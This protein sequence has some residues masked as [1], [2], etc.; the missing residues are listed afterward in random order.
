MKFNYT[1][2]NNCLYRHEQSPAKAEIPNNNTANFTEKL[3]RRL[4]KSFSIRDLLV[5]QSR[6]FKT[7]CHFELKLFKTYYRKLFFGSFRRLLNQQI[8]Y[9]KPANIYDKKYE[10]TWIKHRHNNWY[11][12]NYRLKRLLQYLTQYF[13]IFF[14]FFTLNKCANFSSYYKFLEVFVGETIFIVHVTGTSELLNLIFYSHGLFRYTA[15]QLYPRTAVD[16]CCRL[17]SSQLQS[18]AAVDC[19]PCNR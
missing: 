11:F 16:S 18:P 13:S 4:Y 12:T 1:L 8:F 3:I 6:L 15:R 10:I 17:P 5:R 7:N 9:L 14:S 19:L 2:A